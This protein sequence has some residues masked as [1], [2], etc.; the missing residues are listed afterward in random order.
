MQRKAP[1]AAILVLGPPDG[2]RIEPSCPRDEREGCAATA[3]A[4]DPCVWREPPNLGA[5]RRIQKS[6]AA[7]QGWAFWDWSQA[8]GGACGM[9]RLFVHDPPWAF[10]D[11]VHLNKLGYDAAADVLFFDLISEYERWK[12]SRPRG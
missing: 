9:H 1:Q 6:V 8:M 2:N 11:H 7:Q 5:V 4:V 10:P 3:T 12:K